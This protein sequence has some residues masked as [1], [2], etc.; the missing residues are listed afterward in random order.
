LTSALLAYSRHNLPHAHGMRGAYGTTMTD[1]TY[2]SALVA[3]GADD[4]VILRSRGR[5]LNKTWSLDSTGTP[6]CSDYD[7]AKTFSGQIDT[8]RDLKEFASVLQMLQT[9]RQA[10]HVRAAFQPQVDLAGFRRL[11]HPQKKADGQIEPPTLADVPRRHVLFDIDNVPA[12][13][14]WHHHLEAAALDLVE[15]RFPAAFQGCSFVAIATASAGMKPG[16]RLRL[17]FLLEQPMYGLEI[18]TLMADAPIDPVTLKPAQL[19]YTAAPTFDG[20]SDPIRQRV[21]VHQGDQER[22]PLVALPHGQPAA[23]PAKPAQAGTAASH[24][25]PPV[26][27]LENFDQ[28]WGI[29]DKLNDAGKNHLLA[30]ALACIDPATVG[31]DCR[32]RRISMIG[33]ALSTGAPNAKEI[34]HAQYLKWRDTDDPAKQAEARKDL[35]K[36]MGWFEGRA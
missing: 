25:P 9:D 11:L 32:P 10:A 18:E 3:A 14:S 35:D 15:N 30:V 2:P 17:G 4:F 5:N 36:L 6:H 13:D 12:A 24:G 22:V 29:F 26:L 16:L 28:Y 7:K 20:L 21:V 23:E 8:V 1:A 31:K 19:I 34:I 27:D 33:S